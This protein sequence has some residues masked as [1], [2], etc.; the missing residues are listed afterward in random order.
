[1]RLWVK[2]SLGLA[3]LL[4]TALLFGAAIPWDVPDRRSADADFRGG[5]YFHAGKTLPGRRTD[6]SCQSVSC[7]DDHPH[8]RNAILSAFRNMHVRFIDCLSCHGAEFRNRWVVA[9]PVVGGDTG[10]S[11]RR[12][13]IRYTVPKAESKRDEHHALLVPPIPCRECHSDSGKVALLDRG[14][15]ELT[16][17]F[18]NPIPLRM[19]EEGAKSWIPPDMR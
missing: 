11:D 3:A 2:S 9:D 13:K 4:V 5:E 14:V 6:P 10:S 16:A 19:I 17:G 15:A 1:M 7:H 8:E 12:V 18:T